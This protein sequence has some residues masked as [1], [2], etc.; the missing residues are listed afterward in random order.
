LTRWRESFMTEVV[1]SLQQLG[2]KACPVCGSEDSLGIGRRPVLLVDGEF[3]PT[4]INVPLES[5]PD[6]QVTFAVQIECATCG[7]IMLFNSERHRTGDEPILLVGQ[8]DDE[9]HPLQG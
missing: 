7:H 8:V 5:D 2:V 4:M 9:G 6:R 1:Q 3:P